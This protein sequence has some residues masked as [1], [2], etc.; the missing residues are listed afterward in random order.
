MASLIDYPALAIK[1]QRVIEGT[2]RDV[3]F[4]RNSKTPADLT[5]PWRNYQT[6]LAGAVGEPGSSI[7]A[8]AV[9][10]ME[11]VEELEENFN[12]RHG[13]IFYYVSAKSLGDLV[14]LKEYDAVIDEGKR[15]EIVKAEPIKPGAVNLLFIVQA[16][17]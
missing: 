10:D 6:T 4:V 1:V 14:D 9:A 3:S 13:D 15:F 8:K 16:R 7:T 17:R 11:N 2:G 5:K 12:I